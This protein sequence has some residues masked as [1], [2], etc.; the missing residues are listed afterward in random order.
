MLVDE[1]ST[2]VKRWAIIL[3]V[4]TV[5]FLAHMGYNLIEAD[6]FKIEM[7]E[8]YSPV[9]MTCIEEAKKDLRQGYRPELVQLP[10]NILSLTAKIKKE[11]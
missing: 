1:I 8:P 2:K 3:K 10:N 4:E 5:G 11:W 7:K 9:Y 6:T